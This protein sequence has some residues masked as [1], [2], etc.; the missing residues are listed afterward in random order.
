VI[1]PG[2]H[3]QG[4]IWV[5][6]DQRRNYGRIHEGLLFEELLEFQY[7]KEIRWNTELLS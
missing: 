4:M 6:G 2:E 7:L 5:H 1:A 3:G